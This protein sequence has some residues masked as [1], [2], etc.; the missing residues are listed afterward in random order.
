MKGFYD[1][2]KAFNTTRIIYEREYQS[3]K[4]GTCTVGPTQQTPSWPG[5]NVCWRYVSCFPD[6]GQRIREALHGYSLVNHTCIYVCLHFINPLQWQDIYIR[7]R[8]TRPP[9]NW[10]A[11]GYRLTASITATHRATFSLPTKASCCLHSVLTR[12]DLDSTIQLLYHV[13]VS[14]AI[15]KCSWLGDDS[16]FLSAWPCDTEWR[17]RVNQSINHTGKLKG[18]MNIHSINDTMQLPGTAH[19]SWRNCLPIF[20]FI[21]V[22]YVCG[23]I[24]FLGWTGSWKFLFFVWCHYQRK[25][26]KCFF[27]NKKL[28]MVL[29]QIYVRYL[30]QTDTIVFTA[31]SHH[32][33]KQNFIA[34]TNI[35]QVVLFGYA[36]FP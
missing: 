4:A 27:V 21:F 3:H 36:I 1:S 10:L 28:N 13:W 22:N 32:S 15:F 12:E 23:S 31:P 19:I 2:V 25:P 30:H 16:C 20:N 24:Q 14:K 35:I 11:P 8:R 29:C 6:L 18:N 7:W 9:R 34:S 33:N 26:L 5:S 17:I